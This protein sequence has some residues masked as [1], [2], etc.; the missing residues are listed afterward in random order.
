MADAYRHDF[1]KGETIR[2]AEHNYNFDTLIDYAIGVRD[3]FIYSGQT[4]FL[5]TKAYITGTIKVFW[6][7]VLMK[8]GS[9]Y[10]Y[11]IGGVSLN[12]VFPNAGWT[13]LLA[14]GDSIS[15]VYNYKSLT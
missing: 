9:S 13:N 11:Y 4:Y 8:E 2:S 3:D 10:D 15:V 5:L 6:N 1:T 14:T 7:G 12:A